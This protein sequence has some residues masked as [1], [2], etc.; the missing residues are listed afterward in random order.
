MSLWL[1]HGNGLEGKTRSIPAGIGAPLE[2]DYL[3]PFIR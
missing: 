3:R 1:Q 2:G